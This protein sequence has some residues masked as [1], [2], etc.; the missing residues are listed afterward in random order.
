MIVDAVRSVAVWP[1]RQLGLEPGHAVANAKPTA[2]RTRAAQIEEFAYVT[3]RIAAHDERIAVLSQ[4]PGAR[5]PNALRAMMF[6]DGH[7][8]KVDIALADDVLDAIYGKA[9]RR[10][11]LLRASG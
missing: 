5:R 6:R 1:L 10:P 8:V 11:A 3:S 2:E 4:P 7:L 9:E